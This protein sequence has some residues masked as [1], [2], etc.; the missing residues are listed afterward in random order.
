MKKKVPHRVALS[1][2]GMQYRVTK[3]TRQMISEH[4]R[5]DGPLLCKLVREPSNAVD[6]NAIR[7]L[8]ADEPYTGLF[9]GYLTRQVAEVLAPALDKGTAVAGRCV[10][11]DVAP[12]DGEG[13][14]LVTIKT[15]VNFPATRL[16]TTG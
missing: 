4:V 16:K 12:R 6:P 15:N 8:I 2:V 1:V 14:V 5:N 9:I 11:T 10:L 3:S 13:E 7:V